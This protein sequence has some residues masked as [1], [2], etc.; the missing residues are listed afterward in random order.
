MVY[1]DCLLYLRGLYSWSIHKWIDGLRDFY[2]IVTDDLFPKD[3]LW[4]EIY[5]TMNQLQIERF[6][7]TDFYKSA[8][9]F[10]KIVAD[11]SHLHASFNAMTSFELLEQEYESLADLSI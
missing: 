6:K 11:K 9:E 1:K 10:R 8:S 2:S 5:P 3:L 4:N 7:E